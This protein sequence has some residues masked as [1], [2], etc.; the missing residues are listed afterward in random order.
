MPS[1]HNAGK[2]SVAQ[3][4]I[5][6]AVIFKNAFVGLNVSMVSLRVASRGIALT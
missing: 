1:K 2:D 3:R 5:E 6:S 4:S